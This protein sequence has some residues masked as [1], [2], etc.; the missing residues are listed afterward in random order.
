MIIGI[1]GGI[2][3]GKSLVAKELY[4]FEN[5]VYYHADEEA[6]QLVNNSSSIKNKIIKIFGKESYLDG[7]LNRKFISE[8]VFKDS[9]LLGKLNGIIHPEVKIHFKNFIKSQKINALILYENAILFETNS[10]LLCDIIISITAP[11]ELRIKRVMLRDNVAKNQVQAI[12]K[13]Q[14]SDGKRN[15]LSNYSIENIEKE[16]TMLK[17]K[18][19]YNILTKNQLYF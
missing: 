16:E 18:Y 12:I 13:N 11:K 3:S 7:K 5:T 15:L 2:G 19:I 1:T 9:V 14:W 17:I 6:K 4:S 10:D 8:L